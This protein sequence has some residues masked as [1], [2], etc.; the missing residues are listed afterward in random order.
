MAEI[1]SSQ[2]GAL[3]DVLQTDSFPW[4][5]VVLLAGTSAG[6][7][8]LALVVGRDDGHGLVV[9][10]LVS[11]GAGLLGSAIALGIVEENFNRRLRRRA[12]AQD[13]VEVLLRLI[14]SPSSKLAA[15]SLAELRSLDALPSL[16]GRYLSYAHLEGLDLSDLDLTGTRLGHAR[17]HGSD[18]R[19]AILSGS[20]VFTS[21]L[22]QADALSDATMPDG[23]RYDGRLR[24]AGD[25]ARIQKLGHE[26]DEAIAAFYRI[27]VTD[28]VTGQA[29]A[30]EE[31]DRIR[32]I[33]ADPPEPQNWWGARIKT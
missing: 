1:R 30:D 21:A 31:L 16:C 28:Y 11:L 9:N 4:I 32:R 10:T 13:R 26:S 2:N 22:A 3:N 17:L 6:L 23:K 5:P 19:R 15:E 27:S 18:L 20:S 24:L 14:R 29:W 12:E 33:A 8:I 25:L 7:L